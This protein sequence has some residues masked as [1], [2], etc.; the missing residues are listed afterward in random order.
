MPTIKFEVATPCHNVRTYEEMWYRTNRYCPTCGVPGLYVYSDGLFH[1]CT[2]CGSRAEVVRPRSYES[3][4]PARLAALRGLDAVLGATTRGHDANIHAGAREAGPTLHESTT[5]RVVVDPVPD[6][7]W[8]AYLTDAQIT[9]AIHANTAPGSDVPGGVVEVPARYLRRTAGAKSTVDHL[10][11]QVKR[12]WDRTVE[13]D[14][15]VGR[16]Q[17]LVGQLESSVESTFAWVGR[18]LAALESSTQPRTLDPTT[19]TVKK[20]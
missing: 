7:K 14:D 4:M 6:V 13:R 8:Y 9:E 20:V 17:S 15:E 5:G 11:G 12:L 3:G 16:V 19:G 2:A 18:R 1:V 10:E